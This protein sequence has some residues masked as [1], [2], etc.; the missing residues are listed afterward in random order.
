MN[1]E[2]EFLFNSKKYCTLYSYRESNLDWNINP[3]IFFYI[4]KRNEVAF[5]EF[6]FLLNLW[7]VQ[8][9]YIFKLTEFSRSYKLIFDATK[10]SS[11]FNE[12]TRV[13][14]MVIAY[15]RQHKPQPQFMR[16]KCIHLA[17]S[18]ISFA[19]ILTFDRYGAIYIATAL[20]LL[21]W[22]NQYSLAFASI[23]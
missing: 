5:N 21:E 7:N 8:L 12:I 9:K 17:S 1:V 19:I 22:Q 2:L 15:F 10:K 23:Q 13:I 14:E 3:S 20:L 6:N 16:M 11:I 4:C 18:N